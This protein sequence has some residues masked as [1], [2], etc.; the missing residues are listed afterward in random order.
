MMDEVS[1]LQAQRKR[2]ERPAIDWDAYR[3][4]LLE[5]GLVEERR[6]ERDGF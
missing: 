6:V 1:A 5:S 3:T 2:D 4:A